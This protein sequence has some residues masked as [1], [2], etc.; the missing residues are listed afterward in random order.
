[1]DNWHRYLRFVTNQPAWII[2][3]VVM[4]TAAMAL[5]ASG[6]KVT[7][8]RDLWLPKDHPYVQTTRLIHDIFGGHD[9]IVVG[10]APK[11]GDVYQ[12]AMLEKLARLQ[13]GL[14]GIPEAVPNNVVSF[15]ARKIKAMRGT[16]DGMEVRRMLDMLPASPEALAELKQ[17]V[18]RN[19]F[20]VGALVSRNARFA[21]VIADFK[22]PADAIG[23]SALNAAVERVVE[24]ERDAS[25]DIYIGG[26]PAAY[27]AVE[28]YSSAGG[29]YF[30]IAFVIIMLVQYWSFRSLQ[31]MLLPIVTGAL[32]VVWGLGVFALCG[33][34]LDILNTT[35]PIL[36]MAVTGGHAIQLLKRYYEEYRRLSDAAPTGTTHAELNRA[37]IVQSLARVAPVT[38]AAGVVAAISFFSLGLAHISMVRHFGLFAGVG[39]LSGLAL[40]L[41]LIPALRSMLRPP[42]LRDAGLE[43]THRGIDGLLLSFSDR[44]LAGGASR[45][46]VIGL[47]IV[48]AV[49]AGIFRLRA[50]NSTMQYMGASSSVRTSDRAIN[51]NLGGT[52]TVSF[53]IDGG[54][55]DSI[56]DPALLVAIERLQTFL[57]SQPGVGK[58]QSL[59]DLLKR[60]NQAMHG[61]DPAFF[62]V[63][64]DRA[65]VAQYL[66]LYSLSGD[67]DDFDNYTDSDYRRALVWAFVKNDS[68]AYVEDLYAKAR[69]VLAEFPKGVSVR[70]GGSLAE[71]AA[72]NEVVVH[73]KIVNT[74]QMALVIFLVTSLM[75]RSLVGGLLVVTPVLIIVIM[76]FGAMGWLGI[77]LDM[78]TATTAS[79]AIGIGADYELYL[80]YRFR[81]E[82][83][84][85]G[86]IGQAMRHSLLTSGKAIVFV[87]LAIAG[88]YSVLFASD[89]AFYSRLAA[90]VIMTMVISA[91]SAVVFLR[92]LMIAIKPRFIFGQRAIPLLAGQMAD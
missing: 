63:P 54:E 16:D 13:K 32:S 70:L 20:Y 45:I 35:T 25:V 43:A 71:Q 68:T 21:A 62:V 80:M 33:F 1:M 27:A 65:L 22:L 92:A 56:K 85:N 69:G 42:R 38:V 19:P 48:C 83:A 87:A 53:L 23:Y 17:R 67:P 10:V 31:G 30:G 76:N 88:G 2:A 78:G 59:A 39:V 82:L 5:A 8:G 18:E 26:A 51:S 86:D 55:P 81:E 28:Y 74:A 52:N 40:E 24:R 47:V 46:L 77:P 64:Q 11:Q 75:L 41:T 9:L 44:M 61:D 84:R 73:E 91:L 29:V 57:E 49:G 89:F 12:P 58:T 37:A 72:I 6:L 90:A 15:S 7:N 60:M 36:I 50:D 3:V 66:F 34:D 79:M 14:E 4:V